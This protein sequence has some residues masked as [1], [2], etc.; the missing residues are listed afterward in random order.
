[1][2][3]FLSTIWKSDGNISSELAEKGRDEK[4]ENKKWYHYWWHFVKKSQKPL[5]FF[6][7]SY[8]RNKTN[9]RNK[10]WFQKKNKQQQ[11]LRVCLSWAMHEALGNRAEGNPAYSREQQE[12]GGCWQGWYHFLGAR[13][14]QAISSPTLEPDVSP[15]GEQAWYHLL[16]GRERRNEYYCSSCACVIKESCLCWLSWEVRL[17]GG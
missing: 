11:L 12:L 13:Y 4:E 6:P 7:V 9:K 8:N 10:L 5:W 2:K 1:M 3:S 17:E 14:L 16:G 15:C